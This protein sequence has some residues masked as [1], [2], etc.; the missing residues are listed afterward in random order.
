MLTLTKTSYGFRAV[1]RGTL[2]VADLARALVTFRLLEPEVGGFGYL[3]DQRGLAVMSTEVQ[4]KVRE[5]MAQ[6]L[7][8]GLSRVAI[9]CSSTVRAGRSNA[10][11]DDSPAGR[12]SQAFDGQDPHWRTNAMA[13]VSAAPAL[14]RAGPVDRADRA[15]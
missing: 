3:C 4:A 10:L 11:L 6:L 8:S 14:D 2:T 5:L 9:I 15:A 7:D 13:W 1:A 12:F